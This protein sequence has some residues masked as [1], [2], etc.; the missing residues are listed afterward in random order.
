[1]L[2]IWEVL[3]RRGVS[4]AKLEQS[5]D[6]LHKLQ[7]ES[8]V[9]SAVKEATLAAEGVSPPSQA[10]HC[11]ENLS[12]QIRKLQ[13]DDEAAATALQAMQSAMRK[14]SHGR[15]NQVGPGTCPCACLKQCPRRGQC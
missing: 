11:L 4:S 3:F 9:L 15:R 10:L 12:K 7:N 14:R 5:R 6:I 1:M 2:E 13:G 8:F